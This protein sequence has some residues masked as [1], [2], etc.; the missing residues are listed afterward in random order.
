MGTGKN[1]KNGGLPS[2]IGKKFH[3]EVERIKDAR[4]KN[5]LSRDR[6]STQKITNLIVRHN[7][8]K[9]IFSHIVLAPEEEVNEYG[10]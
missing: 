1:K 7:K 6:V 2:K 4:L 5:G 3:E 8:W 10:L 9:E